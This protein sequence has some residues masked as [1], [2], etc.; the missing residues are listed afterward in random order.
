[1]PAD[2]DDDGITIEEFKNMTRFFVGYQLKQ[3]TNNVDTDR[4]MKLLLEAYVG[5]VTDP[6]QLR[7]S[8]LQV[9]IYTQ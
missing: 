5:G 4:I 6:I 1:M 8:Y 2:P 7:D 9:S 3:T